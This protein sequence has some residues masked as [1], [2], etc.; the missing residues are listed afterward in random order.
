MNAELGCAHVT[1]VGGNVYFDLGFPAEEAAALKARSD[2]I[3]VAELQARRQD[4]GP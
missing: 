3:I 1:P 4:S 2:A